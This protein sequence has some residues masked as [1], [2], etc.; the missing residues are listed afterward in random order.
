MLDEEQVA[1]R[2]QDAVQLAQRPWLVADAAK[3]Q[4]R[5]G[6]V[7]GRVVEG[8]IFGGARSTLANDD[9]SCTRRLSGRSIGSSGSVSVTDSTARP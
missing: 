5:D 4:R 6:N 3:H 8:E 2:S 1:I 7:E 9:C